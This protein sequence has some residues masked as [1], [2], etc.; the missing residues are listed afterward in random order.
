[1]ALSLYILIEYRYATGAHLY[2]ISDYSSDNNYSHLAA[3]NFRPYIYIYIC[4]I[5]N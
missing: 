1:M 5:S 4:Y 2:L 3:A